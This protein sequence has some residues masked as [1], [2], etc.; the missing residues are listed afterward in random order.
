MNNLKEHRIKKNLSVRQLAAKTGV[1]P[2]A[3]NQ[4]ENDRRKAQPKTLSKLA[5]ALEV[6]LDTFDSLVGSTT[7]GS[8]RA[9]QRKQADRKLQQSQTLTT[10][11]TP[12]ATP[13][14]T[15]SRKQ[16]KVDYWV[17]DDEGTPYGLFAEGSASRLQTKLSD[18]YLCQSDSL[19]AAGEQYRRD[20][21]AR[22][23]GQNPAG[24]RQTQ[25]T[26]NSPEIAP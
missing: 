21:F 25:P 16:R 13:K 9:S 5:T 17:F 19:T 18:A 4:I 6:P 8:G 23:R 22:S 15:R 20:L 11:T 12:V 7:L 14:P 3:L 1:D 2:S 24:L 10:P 26:Q